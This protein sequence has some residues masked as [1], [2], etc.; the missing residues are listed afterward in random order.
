M[1]LLPIAG[2]GTSQFFNQP[3]YQHDLRQIVGTHRG[4]PDVAMAGGCD[5]WLISY[6]SI[7][8]FDFYV[9]QQTEPAGWQP[10][11]S[12]SISAAM[13]GGLV[14]IAQQAAGRH[15]GPLNPRLYRASDAFLDVTVG[16]NAIPA[17]DFLG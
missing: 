7:D 14:A 2:G 9:S 3:A 1:S 17:T 16:N 6:T 4:G 5:G 8:V 11:C 10:F 12:S 15:L 13:F